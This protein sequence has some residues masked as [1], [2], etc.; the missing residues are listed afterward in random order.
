LNEVSIEFCK[1]IKKNLPYFKIED[2][3]EFVPS[4]FP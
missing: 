1:I 4:W 2:F 3:I